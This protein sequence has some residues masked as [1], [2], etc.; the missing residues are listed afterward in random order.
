M[1]VQKSNLLH[2][3]ATEQ[4]APYTADKAKAKATPAS[5]N[6]AS[7]SA[8]ASPAKHAHA[9]GAA[10]HS[11][12]KTTAMAAP[13]SPAKH[14][15]VS[16]SKLPLP[17]ATVPAR[18]GSPSKVSPAPVSPLK[19]KHSPASLAL[20]DEIKTAHKEWVPTKTAVAAEVAKH[21]DTIQKR[22]LTHSV[23]PVVTTKPVVK[24]SPLPSPTK[25][26]ASPTKHTAAASP[27]KA[28]APA[29]PAKTTAAAAKTSGT[30]PA[31]TLAGGVSKAAAASPAKLSNDAI[32]KGL[33]AH[34]ATAKPA[35]P[36][37]TVW[38]NQRG[39][40]LVGRP[41]FSARALLQ[42][43]R[44]P[45][46]D[47]DGNFSVARDSIQLP[48]PV[49]WEWVS[50]WMVDMSL[51]VDPD[52]WSYSFNFA[53]FPWSATCGLT[54]YVRRRRWVRRRRAR[55]A[56]ATKAPPTAVA[57]GVPVPA[58]GGLSLA[59][60]GA[61]GA[62]GRVLTA[63]G[64]G[65]T[66]G[67]PPA[68]PRTLI[69]ILQTRPGSYGAP[70]LPTRSGGG[71]PAPPRAGGSLRLDRERLEWL[72]TALGV[73]PT[74]I[75]PSAADLPTSPTAATSDPPAAATRSLTDLRGG[76]PGFRA[77]SGS[78]DDLATPS[79]SSLPDLTTAAPPLSTLLPDT[80]DRDRGSALRAAL[81]LF[82]YDASRVYALTML[83]RAYSGPEDRAWLAAEGARCLTFAVDRRR[84][85]QGVHGLTAGNSVESLVVPGTPLGVD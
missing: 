76:D 8:P 54:S 24:A 26:S 41:R 64:A 39:T 15:P 58:Q 44:G 68:P 53:G 63:A 60:G 84:V 33:T 42:T 67:S 45:W 77:H 56:A 6:K 57:A 70:P 5:P 71:A 48:D 29:S 78:A 36:P 38:E 61:G 82:Q 4:A 28:A 66:A 85:M 69:D 27:S 12:S 55:D 81:A 59:L 16:P 21:G 14:A 35:S 46:S 30:T 17:T 65:A 9:A 18:P 43:D 2:T 3:K 49:R 47:A 62:A 22:V 40:A 37:D 75:L 74:L 31:K 50:D 1:P 72:A 73:L 34:G 52:G 19:G 32:K 13:V 7:G 10:P 11:P 79:L 25:A 51:D 83:M 80:P 20:L 23:E